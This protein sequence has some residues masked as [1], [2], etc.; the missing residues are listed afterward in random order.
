MSMQLVICL[1]DFITRG[2]SKLKSSWSYFKSPTTKKVTCPTA[3]F[4]CNQR[5][6]V[7]FSEILTKYLRLG[8]GAVSG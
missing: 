6:S 5:Q 3:G 4:I 7:T 2:N 1:Y 8:G